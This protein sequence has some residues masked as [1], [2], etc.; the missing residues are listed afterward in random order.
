MGK[1]PDMVMM[2]YNAVFKDGCDL[3]DLLC[4]SSWLIKNLDYKSLNDEAKE[5][6]NKIKKMSLERGASPEW[7]EKITE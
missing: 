5:A 6:I 7:W 3:T 4:Y 1:D 2:N